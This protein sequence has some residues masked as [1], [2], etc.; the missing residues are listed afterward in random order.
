MLI[1]KEDALTDAEVGE[2]DS[3][4]S[5][6]QLLP[7]LQ[8]GHIAA[9]ADAGLTLLDAGQLMALRSLALHQAELCVERRRLLHYPMRYCTDQSNK[10]QPGDETARATQIAMLE[11]E[12]QR[13]VTLAEN[14]QYYRQ[15]PEVMVQ[16]ARRLEWTVGMSTIDR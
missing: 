2:A 9:L 11:Q 4:T 5:L 15:Y 1:D 3:R 12:C 13:W 10:D 6:E 16:I 14:A 7:L 8:G